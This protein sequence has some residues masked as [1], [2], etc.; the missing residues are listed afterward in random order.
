MKYFQCMVLL[1]VQVT[2]KIDSISYFIVVMC[3]V[4]REDSLMKLG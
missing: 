3:K 4:L 1:L 2:R